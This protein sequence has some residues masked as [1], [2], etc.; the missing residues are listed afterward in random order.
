LLCR[1][2]TSRMSMALANLP[3][4]TETNTNAWLQKNVC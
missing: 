4:P 1:S 2:S 3:V